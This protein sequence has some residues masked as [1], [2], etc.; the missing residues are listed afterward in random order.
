[1]GSWKNMLK[2]NKS[3]PKPKYCAFKHTLPYHLLRQTRRSAPLVSWAIRR[4]VIQLLDFLQGQ[5]HHHSQAW[6]CLL[7]QEPESLFLWQPFLGAWPFLLTLPIQALHLQVLCQVPVCL[8]VLLQVPVF[9]WVLLQVPVCLWGLLQVVWVLWLV[10][11]GQMAALKWALPTSML[12]LV[13]GA[14]VLHAHLRIRSMR[15]LWRS[16][17]VRLALKHCQR[18]HILSEVSS[19]TLLLKWVSSLWSSTTLERPQFLLKLCNVEMS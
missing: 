1:M 13:P 18:T 9:L 12:S 19:Q 14:A 10:L 16:R 4:W 15:W 11:W 3:Y 17:D 5:H 7:S 8:W 6:H 2:L